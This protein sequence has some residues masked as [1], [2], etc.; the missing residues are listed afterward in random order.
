M[1]TNKNTQTPAKSFYT[2]LS[3][4]C[5]I[6]MEFSIQDVQLNLFNKYWLNIIVYSRDWKVYTR[7]LTHIFLFSKSLQSGE[8]DKMGRQTDTLTLRNKGSGTFC[9]MTKCGDKNQKC[10]RNSEKENSELKIFENRIEKRNN[11][12]GTMNPF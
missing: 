12:V 5:V 11:Y 1:E 9:L 3:R 4:S 10:C 7:N 2:C 8:G 6:D